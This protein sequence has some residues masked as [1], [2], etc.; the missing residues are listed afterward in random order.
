MIARVKRGPSIAVF[1][2]VAERDPLSKR[3]T[4]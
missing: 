4:I 1:V 3:G 2:A